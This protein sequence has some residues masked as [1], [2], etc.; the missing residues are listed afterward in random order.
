MVL[1][2]LNQ[3]DFRFLYFTM[4]PGT[5]AS[6]KIIE[7]GGKFPFNSTSYHCCRVIP[8][9]GDLQPNSCTTGKLRKGGNTIL[10]LK[11]TVYRR[12]LS[13]LARR[14]SCSCRGSQTKPM[15]NR[16]R[17]GPSIQPP[18]QICHPA[19]Y[20]TRNAEKHHPTR[21]TRCR[22]QHCGA[23]VQAAG[24]ARRHMEQYQRPLRLV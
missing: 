11:Y 3:D 12:Q 16:S 4:Y 8:W 2:M 13:Q 24:P 10:W 5:Q 17:E 7:K 23:A 19:H 15:G 1:L 18:S 20:S 21:K 22:L 9:N 6:I 14:S